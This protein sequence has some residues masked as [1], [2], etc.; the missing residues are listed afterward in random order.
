MALLVTTLYS[1]YCARSYVGWI[2]LLFGLNLSFISSDV[3]GHILKNKISEHGSNTGQ[4]QGRAGQSYGEYMYGSSADDAFPS[5]S[6]RPA[7]RSTGDPSTS[8]SETE[9]TSENEVAR[10]LNC[11]DHY[12]A[13]GFARY[14]NVDISTLKREYRKKVIMH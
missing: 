11:N 8:G 12:S 6:T 10:L 1:M 4:N 13:L 7:D 3:L 9:L 2:G 5:S 14:E